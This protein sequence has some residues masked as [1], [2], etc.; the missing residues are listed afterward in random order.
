MART[1]VTLP[2]R[3]RQ[4]FVDNPHDWLSIED[5]MVKYDV[6]HESAAHMLSAC[7]KD[8]TVERVSVYRTVAAQTESVSEQVSAEVSK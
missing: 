5:V 2:E 3:L 4:Y 7:T 8:G 1:Y 6:S